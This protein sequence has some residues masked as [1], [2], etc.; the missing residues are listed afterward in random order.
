MAKRVY[1]LW[2]APQRLSS[3]TVALPVTL[4]RMLSCIKTASGAHEKHQEERD[5]CGEGPEC[6]QEASEGESWVR[7]MV[8]MHTG[9]F[10]R[11]QLWTESRV[12]AYGSGQSA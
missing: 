2:G 11:R 12:F 5:V 8:Q 6:T 1:E 4:A 7:R 9:G 3:P 10:A